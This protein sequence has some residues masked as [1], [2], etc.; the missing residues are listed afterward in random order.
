MTSPLTPQDR[1]AFYGAAVLGLRAL[2]ARETTPRRFGAD[3]EARWTQFA[4]ALGAGDRIDILLRD[5]AGT[6]G[7]A[8][9]P[10]ECF[11]FFG[12]AD[13]E[14][15]GPD[16]GG[17]D[18]HAAK[19]L[20]AEPDAPATLEHIAYG[21]GVKAAGVPVP[22][23]TPSTKLVVAGATAIVSVAK[24]FAENRALSWTDQVVVVADKAAWRQLAGLAAV[25]LGA[26]GRTV[27]VRPSEGADSALRA[28]GFAHLDAAVVSPDAEPEAAELARKVGGR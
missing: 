8:F 3:A 1:S 6:W 5:A 26:R 11:G 18:D 4:G 17:I 22:P 15:F 2:D 20:L 19:R 12:V 14:P 10:S 13:D 7:A 21:L 25:L 23:I 16:W 9:S 24:V 28:A 27:L